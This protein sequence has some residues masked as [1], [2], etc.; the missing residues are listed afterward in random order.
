M[1]E[2]AALM[3]VQGILSQHLQN[4]LND[5]SDTRLRC[6]LAIDFADQDLPPVDP[7]I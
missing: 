3:Q 4:L 7:K 1:A 2:L 5:I 6:E